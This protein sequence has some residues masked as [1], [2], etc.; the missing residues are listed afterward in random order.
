MPAPCGYLLK[1]LEILAFVGFESYLQFRW[2]DDRPKL[3]SERCDFS[4]HFMLPCR[5][6]YFLT[7]EQHWFLNTRAQVGSLNLQFLGVWYFE[8]TSFYPKLKLLRAWP[9][10]KFSIVWASVKWPCLKWDIKRGM[11]LDKESFLTSQRMLESPLALNSQ[12]RPR[13]IDIPN[14]PYGGSL[15]FWRRACHSHSTWDPSRCHLSIVRPVKC[16]SSQVENSCVMWTWMN[17][18]A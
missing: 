18:R 14:L 17:K 1:N 8:L 3:P 6:Y 9:I 10:L 7:L 16:S 11:I 4:E 15:G 2:V 12:L 5:G 13:A